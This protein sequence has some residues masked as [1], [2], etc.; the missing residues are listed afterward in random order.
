MGPGVDLRVSKDK[1]FPSNLNLL[2][3]SVSQHVKCV[4]CRLAAFEVSDLLHLV[5]NKKFPQTFSSIQKTSVDD[6]EAASNMMKFPVHFLHFFN[7]VNTISLYLLQKI[8]G[9]QIL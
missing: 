2:Q 4:V 1:T 6:F 9:I 5:R 7:L 3:Q 8:F